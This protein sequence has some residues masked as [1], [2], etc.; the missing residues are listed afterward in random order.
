MSTLAALF[1]TE[2]ALDDALDN[3]YEHAEID[4]EQVT[5]IRQPVEETVEGLAAGSQGHPQAIVSPDQQIAT[6]NTL[7][8]LMDQLRAAGLSDQEEIEFLAR[9]L[10]KQGSVA[11]INVPEDHADYVREV[12][13][14]SE[15]QVYKA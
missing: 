9:N 1:G 14:N 13:A 15:A 6:D 11:V 5:L 12:F 3:L 4:D 7:L 8:E 10:K 2:K